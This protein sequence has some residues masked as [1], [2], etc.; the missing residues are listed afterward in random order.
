[1]KVDTRVRYIHINSEEEEWMGYFPPLGTLG[2]VT[3][4][5]EEDILVKWDSGTK[6]DG[7]WWCEIT[8]VEEVEEAN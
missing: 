6:G 8:D 3:Y 1:M 2:T 4:V 7:E 5:G